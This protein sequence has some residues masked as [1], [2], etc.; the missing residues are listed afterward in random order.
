[1]NHRTMIYG[2]FKPLYSELG[3]ACKQGEHQTTKEGLTPELIKDI[4]E[5]V[6]GF[7]KRNYII[8]WFYPA[9]K[10]VH[11][12]IGEKRFF[13]IVVT[14]VADVEKLV[15]V[16]IDYG[17]DY[18]ENSYGH[19]VSLLNYTSAISVNKQIPLLHIEEALGYE[20]NQISEIK[21]EL[22]LLDV[23]KFYEQIYI[24][25]AA[26]E[27]IVTVYDVLANLAYSHEEFRTH[28][29]FIFNPEPLLNLSRLPN[30]ESRHLYNAIVSPAPEKVFLELFRFFEKFYYLP[31]MLP[32]KHTFGIGLPSQ[33]IKPLL[34]KCIPWNPNHG[35]SLSGLVSLLANKDVFSSCSFF[36][37]EEYLK[38]NIDIN[39]CFLSCESKSSSEVDDEETL[40]VRLAGFIYKLRNG[41]VHYEDQNNPEERIELTHSQWRVLNELCV[42]L[43][44]AIY[45]RYQDEFPQ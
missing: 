44:K 28:E 15:D 34:K 32:I 31:W 7:D 11:Y 36:G 13:A 37:L 1:M 22:S 6:R 8:S 24:F 18:V 45:L 27:R 29:E 42:E 14:G 9:N 10:I 35:Q 33:D 3:I 38:I 19:F 43:L 41:N 40:A 4:D 5:C 2:L 17:L 12:Q 20:N 25:S 39:G 30:F 23:M 26:P 21:P 16:I